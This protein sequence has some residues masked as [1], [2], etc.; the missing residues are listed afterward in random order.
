M[1]AGSFG[2]PVIYENAGYVSPNAV[3]GWLV[4]AGVAGAA[5]LAA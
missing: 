4:V 2:G 1:F 3:S 5:G